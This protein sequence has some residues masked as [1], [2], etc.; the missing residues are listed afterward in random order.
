MTVDI[1]LRPIL[2]RRK[3]TPFNNTYIS[4]FSG[5]S[6]KVTTRLALHQ[7]VRR[8]MKQ[9][10]GV[11]SIY[12]CIICAKHF[13]YSSCFLACY[14]TVGG[15]VKIRMVGCMEFIVPLENFFTH[16]ETSPLPQILTYAEHL[17]PLSSE[18]SLTCHTHCDTGLTFIMVI[19]EDPWHSHLM[20]SCHYLFLRLRSVATGD[21]T[22]ISLVRGERS[23]STPPQRS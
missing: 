22:P 4:L 1:D 13:V 18:G 12:I 7:V 16:M 20:W 19:S 5:L 10:P 15:K 21:R 11:T 23:T 2:V 3:L 17:W 6:S 8:F 14:V 9:A